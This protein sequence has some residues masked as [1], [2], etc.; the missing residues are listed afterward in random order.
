MKKIKPMKQIGFIVFIALV[1][2][3][4]GFAQIEFKTELSR[5]KIGLNE[6]VRINFTMNADGDNLQLPS[7]DNFRVVGG[8]YQQMSTSITNGKR[9]YSKS[10]GYTLQPTK[11][12][13]LTIGSAS[14]TIDGKIYK[15]DPVQITITD[16]VQ[17]PNDTSIPL[18]EVEEG[19][20]LVAQVS[21]RNP[22]LN[23][24]ISIL[25][26]LYFKDGLEVRNFT[27]TDNPEYNDFWSHNIEIKGYE[28]KSGTYKGESYSS[29][30]LKKVVLYPQKS[31]QLSISPLT[32]DLV[33][34]VPSNRRDYFGR[35]I[36]NSSNL[37]V[38]TG[39][40][41]V[42][43]K[44]LPEDGKPE[45]FSG[46]VGTFSLVVTP[47]RTAVRQGETIELDVSVNG[48]GNL[49]L[50]SLPKP[51]VPNAL[52]MY[53]PLSK[54]KINVS[55]SGMQGN[56]S[57]KY[58]IIP[59]YQGKY[60]IK[61]IHFSYF[62]L[63]T[64]T[65]KTLSSEEII[66]DMIDGPISNEPEQN[67]T[68]QTNSIAQNEITTANQFRFIALKTNLQP[69]E[70]RDFLFSKPFYF[71]LS[72]PLLLIPVLILVKRKKDERAS[73]IVGNKI[74]STSKLAK[75]YLSEAKRNQDDKQRFY[76]AMERA[77]HN[78]LKAK[79]KIETSEM[80]K[81]KISELLNNKSV[82][83]QTTK[84]FLSL[85]ETA[86]LVRYAPSLAFEIGADYN[87]AVKTITELEKR[88]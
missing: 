44:P 28:T 1:V 13:V 88:I 65:Y 38:S 50:F 29:V 33:L 82:G 57:D 7:F 24:P 66:I 48:K 41:N 43:V 68:N 19:I 46:A 36:Y 42:N 12:G 70:K 39:T 15:T 80:S 16:P 87:K 55:L 52:E 14:I 8:P 81:E 67:I 71:W 10:F 30:I 9:S 75:K 85:I 37:T 18:I 35:R 60:S 61:P 78:F 11:K 76:E 53:D 62:D 72:L 22:Y 51:I 6:N 63:T 45:D 34:G 69:I 77:L 54:K 17:R 3:Q 49:E 2:T 25:Y 47:N 56:I 26:K 32:I 86:E 20:H 5:T 84:D 58:T 83:D 74:R 40:V 23:E 64:E 59:Q 31:G 73:D 79:L 4:L 27:T 21:K